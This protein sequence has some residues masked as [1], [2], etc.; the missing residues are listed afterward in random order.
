[1]LKREYFIIYHNY[2]N[3]PVASPCLQTPDWGLRTSNRS[4]APHGSRK[5]LDPRPPGSGQPT[6]FSGTSHILQLHLGS[7]HSANRAK[8]GSSVSK[9]FIGA[10][11][12]GVYGG[13]RLW[14]LEMFMHLKRK[15]AGYM[16]QRLC[17]LLQRLYRHVAQVVWSRN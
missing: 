9:Q 4:A 1:M 7:P 16:S 6:A 13:T 2:Y 5:L 14:L 11:G 3:L 12:L 8:Q 17:D 10:P 15:A